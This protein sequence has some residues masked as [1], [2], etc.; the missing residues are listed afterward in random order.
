MSV[1][2]GWIGARNSV[3]WYSFTLTGTTTVT[4]DLSAEAWNNATVSLELDRQDGSEVGSFSIAS[5]TSDASIVRTL[6]AGTYYVQVR[7]QNISPGQS[8]RLSASA[9]SPP[10]GSLAAIKAGHAIGSAYALG[11]ASAS[12]VILGDA[13]SSQ[14]TNYYA[15]TLTDSEDVRLNLAGISGG[16]SVTV[17]LMNAQ[18]SS[19]TYS[20]ATAIHNGSI[21][22]QLA[23]GS[24]IVSVGDN[25]A[26]TGYALSIDTAPLPPP[27]G[28]KTLSSATSIATPGT[29]AS[30][31]TD[32]LGPGESTHF[33]SFTLTSPQTVLFRLASLSGGASAMYFDGGYALFGADASSAAISAQTLSAGTHTIK[34]VADGYPDWSSFQLSYSTSLPTVGTSSS[35]VGGGSFLA[36]DA[37]G[38]LNAHS[39]TVADWIGT[40]HT[41]NY[42]SFTLS[43]LSTVEVQLGGVSSS[44]VLL[45]LLS[46]DGEQLRYALPDPA[47]DGD[48]IQ[49]LGPGTYYI[50]VSEAYAVSTGYS[51][52]V[53][54]SPISTSGSSDMA[55]APSID[56]TGLSVHQALLASQGGYLPASSRIADSSSAILADLDKLQN[57]VATGK[58]TGIGLTDGGI[59]TLSVS[60][61]QLSSDSGAIKAIT[62]YFTLAETASGASA[63]IVGAPNALGNTVVFSGA[64][65]Q[66]RIDAAGDGIHFTVSNGATTDTLSNV[67][68]LQ[69]ADHI[70]I[71]AQA[72]S[73]S[74]VTTGNI[75]ELYGAIFGREPDVAGLAYY[76]QLLAS[77]PSL[78]L[79]DL[80]KQFLASP[81][82]V[83]NPSHSYAPTAA[84]DTQ[85]ITDLYNNLLH[86]APGTGDAAWYEANV[87]A[88]IVGSTAPGSAAYASALNSARAVLATDFS[89]SAEFLADVQVTARNPAD[90][91][92]WLILI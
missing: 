34:V 91:Q 65:S 17:N 51:L 16:D 67:Q 50:H 82:Y 39:V 49:N 87:I 13:V 86:R 33:Y 52:S 83:S 71:V 8:Y 5:Q 56:V 29:K 3:A 15:F 78:A 89:Q 6:D 55:S 40:N 36:A 62:G 1:T 70:L 18:G 31:L 72:P 47:Q 90:T 10:V 58:V 57:L 92:H 77:N 23:A 14:A 74:S 41:D 48:I 85:F 75:T 7:D 84:G 38:S 43:T 80:A 66:Y 32:W 81:E 37:F 54:A 35:M 2:D 12:P 24:Y 11:D 60:A 27:A 42:Y 9:L 44:G 45:S 59:P 22:Y 53:S 68:A 69:F 63:A 73:F 20:T 88:P 21:D 30:S 79:T 46:S 4:L 64:S 25:G 61:E 76:Q 19:L 26:G 28:G